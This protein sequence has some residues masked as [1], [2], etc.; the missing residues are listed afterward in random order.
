MQVQVPGL[1]MNMSAAVSSVATRHLVT[2]SLN[3]FESKDISYLRALVLAAGWPRFM[4]QLFYRAQ[5][6]K[7][8]QSVSA[9]GDGIL[10]HA[11]VAAGEISGMARTWDPA[12]YGVAGQILI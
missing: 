1:H 2:G 10:D 11:M 3:T 8:L 7:S 6:Q 5:R 12:E 9:A 4:L